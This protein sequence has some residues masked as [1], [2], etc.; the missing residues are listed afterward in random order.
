[1]TVRV[2]YGTTNYAAVSHI[3]HQQST[4]PAH[5]DSLSLHH[6][7]I[8][9]FLSLRVRAASQRLNNDC[10]AVKAV[11]IFLQD[12][13]TEW[14]DEYVYQLCRNVF[15]YAIHLWACYSSAKDYKID[16][17][18]SRFSAEIFGLPIYNLKIPDI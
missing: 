17:F 16:I 9:V 6:L 13:W 11:R 5:V 8:L 10:K 18:I 14:G 12:D 7:M 3:Y 2:L 15:Q 4:L 1:V